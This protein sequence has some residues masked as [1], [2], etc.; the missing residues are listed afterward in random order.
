M[1]E[2]AGRREGNALDELAMSLGVNLL[3]L[4]SWQRTQE[5]LDVPVYTP[6]YI[7]VVDLDLRL[8]GFTGCDGLRNNQG[9]VGCRKEGREPKPLRRH[10]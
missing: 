2:A 7:G 10:D 6:R 9:R 8:Q 4:E 1:L 3:A 5:F